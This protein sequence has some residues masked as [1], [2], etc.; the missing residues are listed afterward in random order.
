GDV[1]D[2][3]AGVEPH[4]LPH[5]HREGARLQPDQPGGRLRIVDQR[6]S[7]VL[8]SSVIRSAR[9]SLGSVRFGYP[10]TVTVLPGVSAARWSPRFS[11]REG[12]AS[13]TNQVFPGTSSFT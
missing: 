1:D 4:P 2:L 3:H 8:P 13:T 6:S 5:R 7:V 10:T 9:S 11:M 12:G